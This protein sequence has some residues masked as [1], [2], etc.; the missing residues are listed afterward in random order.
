MGA[1]A[2]GFTVLVLDV[3]FDLTHAKIPDHASISPPNTMPSFRHEDTMVNRLV[4]SFETSSD[5][6][7]KDHELKAQ[8]QPDSMYPQRCVNYR[9]NH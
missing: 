3:C 9:R 6:A 8:Q 5:Q 1:G 7:L 4:K 2:C